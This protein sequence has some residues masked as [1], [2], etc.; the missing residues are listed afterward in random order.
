MAAKAAAA[1]IYVYGCEESR[2]QQNT[3]T[4]G[5][6][7]PPHIDPRATNQ[8]PLQIYLLYMYLHMICLY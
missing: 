5:T 3:R 2:N 7:L 1:A 4:A 8:Y 6:D